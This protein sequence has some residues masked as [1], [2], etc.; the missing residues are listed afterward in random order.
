MDKD[1]LESVKRRRKRFLL[2]RLLSEDGKSMLAFLKAI[3]IKDVYMSA[4]AWNDLPRSTL[5]KSWNKLLGR[6]DE[7]A[8]EGTNEPVSLA[9]EFQPLFQKLNCDITEGKITNG[10]SE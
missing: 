8:G 2:Q 6:S 9:T 10:L 1:F 4:Q 7:A 3:D 5:L